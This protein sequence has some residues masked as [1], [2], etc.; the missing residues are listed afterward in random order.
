VAGCKG[1]V[2]VGIFDLYIPL[3]STDLAV[4][5][6]QNNQRGQNC[7]TSFSHPTTVIKP[8]TKSCNQS[9]VV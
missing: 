8:L 2:A 3:V 4:L 1:A 6:Y 7:Y 5:D 9:I